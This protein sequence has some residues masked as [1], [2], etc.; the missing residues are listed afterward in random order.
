MLWLY[1]HQGFNDIRRCRSFAAPAGQLCKHGRTRY[2]ACS[3][4]I[5]LQREANHVLLECLREIG[6]EAKAREVSWPVSE[7]STYTRFCRTLVGEE[8]YRAYVF[9]NDPHRH[10]RHT[11][12]RS[13][14]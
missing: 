2:V 4:V 11:G 5:G 12:M 6:I 14:V 13:L 3:S 8:I 1:R 10:V 7:Y 9:G